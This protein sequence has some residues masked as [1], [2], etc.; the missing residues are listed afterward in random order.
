MTQLLLE[1]GY[2]MPGHGSNPFF[3]ALACRHELILVMEPAQQRQVVALAPELM[4]RVHLLGRWGQGAIEDPTGGPAAGYER[5]LDQLMFAVDAWM[6]R[7]EGRPRALP[8][9][10]AETVDA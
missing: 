3:R 2:L 4:G 1:R 5:C 7:L 10:V 8:A 9:R 6:E